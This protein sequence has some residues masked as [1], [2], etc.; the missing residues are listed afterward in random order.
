MR[1]IKVKGLK[2][3]GRF[4]R[5]SFAKQDFEIEDFFW[6]KGLKFKQALFYEQFLLIEVELNLLQE[7]LRSY[8]EL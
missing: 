3:C 7:F 1:L 8:R 4:A 6:L 5:I 2:A